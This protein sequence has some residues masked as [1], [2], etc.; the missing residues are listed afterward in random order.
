[1]MTCLTPAL[2]MSVG[3]TG[4]VARLALGPVLA[5][6]LLAIA[7]GAFDDHA[8]LG[9]TQAWHHNAFVV[10]LQG[11]GPAGWACLALTA[12]AGYFVQRTY[13]RGGRPSSAVPVP[14]VNQRDELPFVANS[15]EVAAG[16]GPLVRRE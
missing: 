16:R 1:M 7:F 8:Y 6:Q 11:A 15:P 4:R 10:A 13:R 9:I 3:R 2:A 14:P 12:M 5:V